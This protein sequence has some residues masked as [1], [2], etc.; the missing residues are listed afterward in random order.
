MSF[1]KTKLFRGLSSTMITVSSLAAF[2]SVLAFE[3]SGQIN[4]FL[5][6]KPPSQSV[7]EDT[8][9]YPSAYSSKEEMRAAEVE[10]EI[11]TQQEGSVLLM[12]KNTA[13]PLKK[14]PHITLFG[15]TAADPIYRGGSGGSALGD[16]T[17]SLYNAL[18]E[19]GV[20]INDTVFNALKDSPIKRARG[21]I[22]EVDGSF[23]NNLK[24]S[25]ANDYNDAAVVVLGRYSG[26]Q[27]DYTAGGDSNADNVRD[28]NGNPIDTDGV[29]ML[30]LHKQER[31]LLSMIKESGKFSKVIVVLNTGAPMDIDD[32]ESY[33]VDSILW[34]GYPGYTGFKGVADILV[35]NADPSGR[36]V[37]TYA[38]NSLSSPAM[39][40]YGG[41]FN[42]SNVNADGQ[43]KY[44]IYAEGIYLGYKYYET[45]YQ[46][47]VLGINNA[48]STKGVYVGNGN[49]DY[50]KEMTYTFGSGQSYAQFSQELTSLSWN[51]ETHQVTAKVHVTN[52][53][54][55]DGSLYNGKSKDVVQLYAQLPY[56]KGQAE[57]SAIQLIGYSKTKALAKGESDDITITVDDYI[58]ATYDNKAV[59]GADS[60]KKGCY[61][62]D[63]GDYLFAIGDNAHDALNNV[64]A[65][66]NVSGLFD[67]E[68]KEVTGNKDKVHK[69][70][71]AEL[72]NV[73]HAKS[74][75]GVIVSNIFDDIDINY[76][77]PN[78]VT[79]L[80]RS[81][82]NT[83]PTR[84]ENLTATE[85]MKKILSGNYYQKPAD[86]PDVT[87]FKHDEPVT[88]TFIEMKDVPYEDDEKWD[89][90]IDQLSPTQIAKI[91]GEKFGNDAIPA[92]INAPANSAADGPDGIQA[93]AGFSH[94]CETIAV[95][96]FNDELLKK[97]GEF[98]AEDGMYSGQHGV[99]GFGAN[100][101][102]TPYGG[103][104]FEYYSEDMTLSY[105]AGA[106][107]TKAAQDKGL[108]TYV[109]HFC[110]N[111]QEVWRNGNATMMTEQ[112][113][114]QGPLK[115]FE[116]SFTKG[117]S[118]GTMTSNARCGLRVTSMS[119][120]I[121]T[122]VLRKEWGFKGLSMTDSSKGS[123]YYIYTKE[124]LD[125]GIDQFN[126]D[127][128]RGDELKNFMIKDRD[129]HMWERA[130]EI[131]KNYFYTYLHCF[132]INGL[133]PNVE[134][135]DF[136]PFWETAIYIADAVLAAFTIS[137]I[138]LTVASSIINSKKKEEE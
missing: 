63:E 51:R 121:M 103:R 57:K 66:R 76:F 3:N 67:E 111:D 91:A 1:W 125:A 105:L 118:L 131:A 16:N 75:T 110:A 33:G 60:T 82:W 23:Y 106:V 72:D 61:V 134:I 135:Q 4:V 138:G 44:L 52:N 133:A 88:K 83:Y 20:S 80:T 108:I 130:R 30:S 132:V 50:A 65:S 41:G 25:F 40:N 71:L 54:V 87:S 92:P 101:H 58:F 137:A 104:N 27:Q 7:T 49:W 95:S 124:S 34:V 70:T 136:V 10:N 56:E 5:G 119:K 8:N 86:A 113:F 42:W 39:R 14:N 128:T 28:S 62:F 89:A 115:G 97:R 13:L 31:D 90:F 36:T 85:E 37:D 99:Y 126:N 77:M 68:G 45:R 107:Q 46:D 55:E 21:N 94:V 122:Q 114:R 73:T 102:R 22:G 78:A 109:K 15:R 120:E 48:T 26:E 74:E 116:G 43:N 38:T 100:M 127:E 12:N 69:E 9:Y 96:T 129:G 59:N 18:K 35:G 29:A 98:M 2:L 84:Y 6:C 24:S 117:G 93:N 53:G 11:Q 81:D 112:A 19:K 32:L 47:Q 17:V 64:L 79:Y 123:R